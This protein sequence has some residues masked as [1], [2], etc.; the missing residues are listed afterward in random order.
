MKNLIGYLAIVCIVIMTSCGGNE[1]DNAGNQKSPRI[2]KSSRLIT[3][4]INQEFILGDPVSFKISST[5]QIDSVRLD[6]ENESIIFLD[7]VFTW[8]ASKGKTG[9]Q[10]LKLFVFS[11]G[12]QEV[13]YPR[14]KFFSDIEPAPYTYELI[15]SYPHDPKAFTQGLYFIG[16][17][18]VESTGGHGTSVISMRSLN[19]S[20][21]YQSVSLDNQYFGE[22]C[23][24]WNDKIIMLSWTSQTGFVFDKSFQQMETFNYPHEGWG[25]TTYGDTLIVSDGTEVLHL[26]DP[27]DFSEIGRLEVYTNEAPVKNLNELEMIDGILYAN[28]WLED[29]IVSIDPNSGKVLSVIDL[30]GLRSQLNSD[31]NEVLNGIAYKAETGQIFVTGKLWPKLFEVKFVP[32]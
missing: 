17:T 14:V 6:Y 26:I 8:K 10:Q 32:N 22:G 19:S 11:N 25:I 5:K 23:T 21:P 18:L 2:K 24:I 27:R 4:K 13:H 3:P 12:N 7:S 1:R 15:Q 28:V 9:T 20:K 31:D 30:S 29:Q 16:D